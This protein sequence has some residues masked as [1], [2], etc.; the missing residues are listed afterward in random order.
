MTKRG[1]ETVRKSGHSRRLPRILR[2]GTRGVELLEF[3]LVL[4]PLLG[5]TF[6]TIDIGWAIF[7]RSTLQHAVRE[8]CR[9]AITSQ[10]L[11]GVTDADGNAYGH[12]DSIKHVVQHSAMGVLGSSTTD[13]GWGMIQ[14]RFYSPNDLANSLAPPDDAGDPAI[15]VGGNIVEVSVERFRLAPLLP[16]LRDATPLTFTARSADRMEATPGGGPPKYSTGLGY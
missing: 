2:G 9:Y 13:S 5:F 4:L 7:A 16:L 12:L 1:P 8:G 11:S 15:N 10:T 14:V 6:V 3:T